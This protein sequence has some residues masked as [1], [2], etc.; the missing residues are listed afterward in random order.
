MLDTLSRF[1]IVFKTENE[2]NEY[3]LV[4]DGIYS[5]IILHFKCLNSILDGVDIQELLI[6]QELQK[7]LDIISN[8]ENNAKRVLAMKKL[9]TDPGVKYYFFIGRN[10]WHFQ[11]FLKKVC[12]NLNDDNFKGVIL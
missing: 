5:I 4:L 6:V 1:E 10:R 2:H 3:R 11:E 8:D 9:F 12:D 7:L